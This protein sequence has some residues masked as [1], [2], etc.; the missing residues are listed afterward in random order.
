MARILA[1]LGLLALVALPA[2]AAN[3]QVT[4]RD[5]RFEPAQITIQPG[6][7]VTWTNQG[8]LPHNVDADDG[9]F[10]CAQGCNDTGGN[11]SPSS[12][13]WSFTR[14][15]DDPGDIPYHCDVHGA[16]GG[17]RMSGNVTV[18]AAPEPEPEGMPVN[19]GHTGSWFNQGTDGQGFSIEVVVRDGEPAQVVAY[20]FTFSEAGDTAA[21]TKDHVV[22]GHRWFIAVGDVPDEGNEVALDVFISSGGRFD[23]APPAP[24][25][26]PTGTASLLFTDCSEG[27][28]GYDIDLH[29]TDAQRVTGEIPIVRLN[30][31]VECEARAG[32]GN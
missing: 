15:F 16:P 8:N 32:N 1:V 5:S 19:F 9:S 3:H 30:P 26:E 17:V 21:G 10:T 20:W 4:V 7:T 13:N 27:T 28:F 18:E 25:Q 22:D 12:A 11:G 14:T 24:D 31:D 23:A 6:D 2:R 29:N